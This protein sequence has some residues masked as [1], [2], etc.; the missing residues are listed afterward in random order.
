MN[1]DIYNYIEKFDEQTKQRFCVLHGLVYESTTKSINELLWAKLPSFYN[2][3]NFIRII[4]FR[5]HINIEAK[6]ILSHV[7]EL[8]GYKI[9]PKGML[10]IFHKQK[11]PDQVLKE[12]FKKSLE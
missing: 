1:E 10:Q 9:T 5:D 7:D 11:V 8:T 6:D 4:P 12:I 3:D 2:E